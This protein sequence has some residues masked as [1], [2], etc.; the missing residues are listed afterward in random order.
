[1]K[2]VVSIVFRLKDDPSLQLGD[3][4]TININQLQVSSDYVARLPLLSFREESSLIFYQPRLRWVCHRDCITCN[5]EAMCV[6][7]CGYPCVTASRHS[8]I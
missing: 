1:M 5:N 3:V 4:T 7:S 2:F 8:S 6:I